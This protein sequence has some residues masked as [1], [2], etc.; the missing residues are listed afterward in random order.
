M[1]CEDQT[2]SAPNVR[3]IHQPSSIRKHYKSHRTKQ[4]DGE[5]K[6]ASSD[7]ETGVQSANDI[8]DNDET[9]DDCIRGAVKPVVNVKLNQQLNCQFDDECRPNTVRSPSVNDD[10]EVGSPDLLDCYDNGFNDKTLNSLDFAD[11][12]MVDT[13]DEEFNDRT[14]HGID[15]LI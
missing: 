13:Y 12:D 15:T 7:S 5:D 3:M 10:D 1:E 14:L 11:Q 8:I 4:Y 2:T 9:M 6:S